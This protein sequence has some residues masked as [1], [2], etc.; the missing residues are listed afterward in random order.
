MTGGDTAVV[1]PLAITAQDGERACVAGRS[2]D[3]HWLRPEPVWLRD[4]LISPPFRYGRWTRVD[5]L[6]SS[7]PEPRPEDRDI[8][9]RWT[10][11]PEAGPLDAEERL[12]L[13]AVACDPCVSLALS[14]PRSLG[15]VEARVD[16]LRVQRSTG[17]RHFLRATF[18]DGSGERFDWVVPELQLMD[19]VW[20]DRG[21]PALAAAAGAVLEVLASARVFLTVG[22]TRPNGRFPGRFAGCHPLVVGV[23]SHPDYL[24]SLGVESPW[25]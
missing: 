18:E 14:P 9:P 10:P 5:L 25:T 19:V 2:R 21:S 17:G 15:M 12:E 20:R 11:A 3:G 4:L 22:L 6:P 16:G 1:L 7:S 23:H 24:T 8:D 13:L